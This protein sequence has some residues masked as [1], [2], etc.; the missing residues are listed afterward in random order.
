MPPRRKAPAPKTRGQ[1]PLRRSSRITPAPVPLEDVVNLATPKPEVSEDVF[2]DTAKSIKRQKR[3]NAPS[4]GSDTVDHLFLE[5]VDDVFQ[6]T[7]HDGF[8]DM[9][10]SI[11]RQKWAT[12]RPFDSVDF[13]DEDD[14]DGSESIATLD[15]PP[16][17]WA[18]EEDEEEGEGEE[19]EEEVVGES[20]SV[21]DLNQEF[22]S[23][24]L[25]S[26]IPQWLRL[27][28]EFLDVY[29]AHQDDEEYIVAWSVQ[30]Q[31]VHYR[32]MNRGR[33]G[34]E[35]DTYKILP[36]ADGSCPM[37]H[38]LPALTTNESIYAL[39][40]EQAAEYIEG[41]C[42]E[43]ALSKLYEDDADLE[44]IQ[45]IIEAFLSMD[46]VVHPTQDGEVVSLSGIE[47]SSFYNANLEIPMEFTPPA[48]CANED[49]TSEVN[50]E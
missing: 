44:D 25:R 3:S 7:V 19:E 47:L 45:M 23:A 38:Q 18:A 32:Q 49:S 11:A 34:D 33:K 36:F 8:D 24:S 22:L 40:E 12:K 42:L 37:H 46:E 50:G 27:T 13:S 4:L 30:T 5:T 15:S 31:W 29:D 28:S 43:A 35:E 21:L 2:E 16:A 6:D 20:N 10:T 41:Y 48:E 26:L 14:P 17:E 39:T 1:A 9:A